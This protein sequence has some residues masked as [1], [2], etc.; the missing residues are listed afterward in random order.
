[1]EPSKELRKLLKTNIDTERDSDICQKANKMMLE[2]MASDKVCRLRKAL[3][4]L[5]QVGRN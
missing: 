2:I 4:G 1:M 5:R 3:Y